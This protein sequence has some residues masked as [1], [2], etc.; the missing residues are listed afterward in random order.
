MEWI[1]ALEAE[2]MLDVSE[3]ATRSALMRTK[4]A[5]FTRGRLSEADPQW[6]KHIILT[7]EGGQCV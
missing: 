7:R 1:E 3:M 4:R 5:D 2:N 6:L